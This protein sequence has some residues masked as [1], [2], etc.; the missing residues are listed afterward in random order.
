MNTEIKNILSK[1]NKSDPKK[2]MVS[3][4]AEKKE[5]LSEDPPTKKKSPPPTKKMFP[6]PTKKEFFKE[7]FN[8]KLV[9]NLSKKPFQATLDQK[10]EVLVDWHNKN[11]K[12]QT[13]TGKHFNTI[14]PKICFKQK[15]ISSWVSE[16]DQI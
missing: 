16:E 13:G 5:E 1:K 7:K 9:S 15:L 8:I 4:L 11:G 2:S 12:N 14:Y 10:L 6:P 3:T